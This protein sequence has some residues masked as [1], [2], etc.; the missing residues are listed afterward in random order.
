MICAVAIQIMSML[1]TFRNPYAKVEK[2]RRKKDS[3]E[4]KRAKEQLEYEIT[5]AE[6]F[7]EEDRIEILKGKLAM[8]EVKQATY[9]EKLTDALDNRTKKI[10]V[11]FFLLAVPMLLGALGLALWATIN[12]E[13]P[14]FADGSSLLDRSAAS[15]LGGRSSWEDFVDTCCVIPSLTTMTGFNLTE[16]WI[17]TNLTS[18]SNLSSSMMV[19]AALEVTSPLTIS[20]NRQALVISDGTIIRRYAAVDFEAP[21]DRCN[22]TVGDGKVSFQCSEDIISAGKADTYS[23]SVLW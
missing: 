12:A 23:L 15:V 16:R 2:E 5:T 7:E 20:R 22:V 11:I 19:A 21:Y 18:L 14:E 9:E 10:I 6:A 8:L 3:E 1:D 13:P 4:R 17:C